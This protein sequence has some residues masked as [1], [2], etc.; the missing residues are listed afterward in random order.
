MG[1]LI[2]LGHVAH[3]EDR[4]FWKPLM[5]A[6]SRMSLAPRRMGLIPRMS[7]QASSGVPRCGCG[8]PP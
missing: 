3:G 6:A 2:A 4:T 8:C 7:I 5:S 1:D